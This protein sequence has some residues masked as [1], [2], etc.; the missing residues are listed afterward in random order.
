[1]A[2]WVLM[3]VHFSCNKWNEKRLI[4]NNQQFYVEKIYNKSYGNTLD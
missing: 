2:Y 3:P 4:E 1:M